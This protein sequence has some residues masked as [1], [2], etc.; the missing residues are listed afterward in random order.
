MLLGCQK[1]EKLFYKTSIDFR[2][3]QEKYDNCSTTQTQQ[4]DIK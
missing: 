1:F 2:E 3:L 4:T